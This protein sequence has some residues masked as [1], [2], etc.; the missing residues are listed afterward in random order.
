MQIFIIGLSYGIICDR[1]ARP[2]GE[3]GVSY[4]GPRDVSGAP[5][6]LRN[7]KIHQNASFKKSKNFSPEG[8]RENVSPGLAFD[9]SGDR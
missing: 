8:P 7:T 5:P 4:P 1:Q 2:E 6:P 3:V 9:G